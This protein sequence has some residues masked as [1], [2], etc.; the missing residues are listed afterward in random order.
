MKLLRQLFEDMRSQKL[1]GAATVIVHGD[2]GSSAYVH[3]P[4]IQNLDRLTQRDLLEAFSVL[5]AVKWPAGQSR[6]IEQVESLNVLMGGVAG[7]IGGT[8]VPAIAN[9]VYHEPEPFV[10]MS[11][12]EPLRRVY[13]NIFEPPARTERQQ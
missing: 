13:V 7:R 6:V 8:T 10:Y 3:G 11:G 9:A 1:F 5:F 12:D 2:H 4:Y